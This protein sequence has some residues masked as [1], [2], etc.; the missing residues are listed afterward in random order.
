MVCWVLISVVFL[1]PHWHLPSGLPTNSY[2]ATTAMATATAPAH[3]AGD[4]DADNMEG[5]FFA[6][7]ECFPMVT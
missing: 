1:T 6:I 7:V 4:W 2:L 3:D 5:I